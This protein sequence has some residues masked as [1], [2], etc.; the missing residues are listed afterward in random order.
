MFNKKSIIAFAALLQ[1]ALLTGCGDKNDEQN[2]KDGK[3]NSQT[4]KLTYELSGLTK[5]QDGSYTGKV[6][7]KVT[8]K[9]KAE[10]PKAKEAKWERSGFRVPAGS[11]STS[12]QDIILGKTMAI[13]EPWEATFD[14]PITVE[15]T[16]E[17]A[18]NNIKNGVPDFE[19]KE[20]FKIVITQ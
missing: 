11:G 7:T 19:G 12:N 9:A 3:N 13:D 20:T 14:Q 5:A 17:P 4:T 16:F 1:V 2:A 10:G 8:I 6:G 18:S 15:L